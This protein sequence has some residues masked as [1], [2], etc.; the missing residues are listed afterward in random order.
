MWA[1]IGCPQ[2]R[3]AGTGGT[4]LTSGTLPE[5]V[6]YNCAYWEKAVRSLG[7][8]NQIARHAVRTSTTA[9]RFIED[10]FADR[11][12]RWLTPL[13]VI[14][15]LGRFD[16]DPCAAPGHD[17]AVERWTPEE[18]GDGLSLPWHG[19]VW[20][21]PPYGRTSRAWVERLVEHGTGTALL[22]VA[23]GTKL[24]Q[25]VLLPHADAILWWRHRIN[26]LRRDGTEDEMVS[27]AASALI[28]F[29]PVDADALLASR[30][31][32]VPMRLA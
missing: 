32:G 1:A 13:G 29:G 9:D 11:N 14:R 31:P 18:I 5:R 27:P 24:W 4:E 20:L 10:P 15:A 3:Q 6:T 2:E 8:G 12:D 19:R 21:N 25:D 30:L 22:P 23:T 16:L 7:M 17:T 28:A 26:F